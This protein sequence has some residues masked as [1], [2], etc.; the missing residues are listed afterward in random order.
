M[1]NQIFKSA[2]LDFSVS[3]QNAKANVPQI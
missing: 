2:I 3:A 1:T